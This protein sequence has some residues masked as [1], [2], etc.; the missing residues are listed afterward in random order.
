[1]RGMKIGIAIF[2]LVLFAGITFFSGQAN[3]LD[4]LGSRWE[5]CEYNN[6]EWK[7]EWRRTNANSNVF[8]A[9]WRH[10]QH[11]KFQGKIRI[12]LNG[13]SV[14]VARPALGGGPACTYTGTYS[15]RDVHNAKPASVK[16]TYRCGSYTG[17]WRATI[18]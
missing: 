12:S 13:N 7:F 14:T 9:Y 4:R 2:L 18:R 3:A 17:P 16:G 15:K 10:R 8:N 6:C 5:G 1:M 11:G